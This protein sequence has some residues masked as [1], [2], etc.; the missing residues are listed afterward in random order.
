MGKLKTLE[1]PLEY[2]TD[3][4]DVDPLSRYSRQNFAIFLEKIK[5]AMGQIFPTVSEGRKV[6]VSQSVKEETGM[7]DMD[8]DSDAESDEEEEEEGDEGEK[9]DDEEE[10]EEEE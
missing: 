7:M 3:V 6:T 8:L 1:R 2:P 10:E 4:T 9:E 5:F